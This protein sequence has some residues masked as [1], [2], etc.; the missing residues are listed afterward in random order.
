MKNKAIF[1]LVFILFLLV[2]TGYGK[3]SKKKHSN[4]SISLVEAYTQ[5]TLPGRREG[6]IRTETHI[7][8]KWQ[9][10]SLPK[11]FV[12]HIDD[13]S[14]NCGFVKVHKIDKN[15]S[16]K[17][18]ENFGYYPD[19]LSLANIHFGDTLDIIPT[20]EVVEDNFHLNNPNNVLS[21]KYGNNSWNNIHV[22]SIKKKR[23]IAMP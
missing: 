12:W 7:I 11:N 20:G 16:N 19:N 5:R 10:H 14:M 8:I 6:K 21:Y 3:A 4:G 22:D 15:N 18:S 9:C 17:F 2:D 13:K 1:Y 23:D